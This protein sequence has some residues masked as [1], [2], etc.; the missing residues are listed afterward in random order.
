M[1]WTMTD[2]VTRWEPYPI[3]SKT[4]K[5]KMGY[6][7]IPEL[8]VRV[9]VHDTLFLTTCQSLT[10]GTVTQK[11]KVRDGLAIFRKKISARTQKLHT[12]KLG[13]DH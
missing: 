13:H 7:M 5:K 4:I 8:Y 11:A 12:W 1:F 3:G 9:S 10:Y 2:H 6:E